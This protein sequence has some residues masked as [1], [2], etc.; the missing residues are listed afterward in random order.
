MPIIMWE[1]EYNTGIEHFDNHNKQLIL[2]LNNIYDDFV[3]GCKHDILASIMAHLADY[4]GYFFCMEEYSMHTTG[5][6]GANDHI[7]EHNKFR[8][9]IRELQKNY[10]LCNNEIVLGVIDFISNWFFH[11]ILLEDA[12]YG[13]FVCESIR[14]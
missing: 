13:K 6:H 2:L 3:A 1:K 7:A 8:K 5:Y 9:K 12:I 14:T 10:N 11:H 4:N